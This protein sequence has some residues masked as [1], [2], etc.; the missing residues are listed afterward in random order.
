MP[1]PGP[2]AKKHALS[3]IKKYFPNVLTVSDEINK[4]IVIHVEERDC[5]KSKKGNFDECALALAVKREHHVDGALIGA[6]FSYLIKGTHATRYKTPESV[7]REIVSFDR[8]KDFAEGSYHLAT[9]NAS[10]RLGTKRRSS[11][12]KKRKMSTDAPMHKTVRVR[13]QL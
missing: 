10:Q 9:V 6:A 2:G 7:A 12:T 11:T 3:R 1:R 13:A 5:Q 4:G 8:H